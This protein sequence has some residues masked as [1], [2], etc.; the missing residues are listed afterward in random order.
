[1]ADVDSY[2]QI[3]LNGL[4]YKTRGPVPDTNLAVFP[5][6]VTIGDYGLDSNPLLSAWVMSDWTGG[7][8]IEDMN[9][10]LDVNRYKL[11]TLYT[12]YPNQISAPF[13]VVD[14]A[15]TAAGVGAYD[16]RFIGNVKDSATGNWDL[17]YI[18]GATSLDVSSQING[19]LGTLSTQPVGPPVVFQGTSANT[20]IVMPLG[21]AGYAVASNAGGFLEQAAD[22]NHPALQAAVV[23]DNKIIGIDVDGQLWWSVEVSA[24]N[25]TSYGNTAKLPSQVSTRSM[26]TYFDRQ[27]APAIYIVTDTDVWQFDPNGPELWT[28]DVSF[29]PHP[30]QG[31]ASCKWGGDLYFSVGTG[32]HRYT[33]GSLSAVGLD[34]DGGLPIEYAGY[35][36]GGGLVA[37]Y[38]SLFAFVTAPDLSGY[39]FTGTTPT[40]TSAVYEFTGIGW[41][42]I[43]ESTTEEIVPHSMGISRVDGVGD[44]FCL[45]WGTKDA[46]NLTSYIHQLNLP[47]GFF[48]PRQKARTTGGYASSGWLIT[49]VFD[50]GMPGY[51][52]LA[53]ALDVTMAANDSGTFR[54]YYQKDDGISETGAWTQLGIVT[55]ANPGVTTSFPFGTYDQ[56]YPGL[57]FKR[58][59][60]KFS[61]ED[62]DATGGPVI[63]ESA[64]LSFVKKTPPSWSWTV[65]LDL[66]TSDTG[67]SPQVQ[68]D[69]LDDLL[70]SG[71]MVPFV[72]RGETFRVYVAQLTGSLETGA[73][74]S[75]FRRVSLLEV[76]LSLSD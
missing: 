16:W 32:V 31:L 68:I 28:I 43:W 38:N 6:K 58:I 13:K 9:E 71:V 70:E 55:D 10:S 15:Y 7:L 57:T 48:N 2:N 72:L 27:G 17:I 51:E 40:A 5:G 52:K 53:N 67:R 61:F 37:G 64:V 42:M 19:A 60:F 21:S 39:T 26:T 14:F 75:G 66:T 59:R 47:V 74:E 56:I 50:A 4:P 33:G 34:R 45:L 20:R 62:G 3:I 1:M 63:M 30:Y 69:E 35:I 8:G 22:A 11:G 49:G 46:T 44:A 73:D 18:A 12:R 25:W 23:W 36:V 41:H 54:V 76:P 24:A 29:P 65:E